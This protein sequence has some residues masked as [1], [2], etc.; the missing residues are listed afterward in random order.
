MPKSEVIFNVRVQSAVVRKYTELGK[1][2]RLADAVSAKITFNVQRIR[3]STDV[4]VN[5]R[6]SGESGCIEKFSAA[7]RREFP[8]VRCL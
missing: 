5:V 1:I 8:E 3:H 4:M 7:L 2:K 6:T